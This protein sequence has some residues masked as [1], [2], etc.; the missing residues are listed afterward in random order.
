MARTVRKTLNEWLPD[1]PIYGNKGL[2]VA[3]NVYPVARGYKRF[4]ALSDFSNAGTNYLRSVFACE[5]TTGSVKI[6]AGDETKLYLFNSST[7]NL[8]DVSKG[9]GYTLDIQDKW[10]FAQF[11]NVVIAVAGHGET[12]QKFDLGTDSQFSDLATGVNATHL[13]VV[14]DFV[15]TANNSSGINNAR[16]SA[17]GDS[18]SWTSSQTTQADNQDI[19]DL[20]QITGLVGGTEVIILCERGIVLG[21]YVGTP[22]IWQF[23][24]IESNRGCNFANSI[25]NVAQQVFY[26]TDDGFYTFDSRRGSR[27]IGH[28]KVDTFFKNDFNTSYAYKMSSAVD[29]TNK[30]IMWAYTST[31]SSDGSADKILVYNYVLDRWSVVEQASDTLSAILTSGKT[32]EQL[33][34][35]SSS[36]E[37]LPASLDSDL[38]KGGNLLFVGSQNSKISTFTGTS[39]NATLETGEFEHS[40]KRLSLLSQVRPLYEKAESDSATVTVQTGGRRTT[41]DN[42][43]YGSAVTLNTDGFAPTRVNNRYHRVRLNLS[44]DWSSVYA[45]DLDI[46]SVGNR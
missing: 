13:T 29:P 9:G 21:R 42:F 2:S 22:L 37:N 43:T 16:W 17:L 6:F 38:Y 1:Q 3:T 20:G 5:D 8:D 10:K 18:T 45:L 32:L 15:F 12:I 7:Q 28:E 31:S 46:E 26:Y 24:V 4:Q 27:P 44:G 39:L 25:V 34:S 14:R 19:S 23:D 35:I 40:S 36:I 30:L 33:D 11:G 41:A